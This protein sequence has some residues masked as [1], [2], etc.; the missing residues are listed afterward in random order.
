MFL[1]DARMHWLAIGLIT[2]ATLALLVED[3]RPRL[4]IVL[5]AIALVRWIPFHDVTIW[6]ELVV[7]VGVLLV[8]ATTDSR[9][10]LSSTAAIAVAVVTPAYPARGLLFP[11]VIAACNLIPPPFRLGLAV[12]FAGAVPFARYSFAPL[13]IVAAIACAMPLIERIPVIPQ[14]AAV[15]LFALWPWSGVLARS[16]PALL[17]ATHSSAE[18][19]DRTIV[20][21]Q[22]VS[23]PVPRGAKKVT[24]TMAAGRAQHLWPHAVLGHV[25]MNGATTDFAVGDIA[26]FGFMRREHFLT[27]HNAP[28]RVPVDDVHDFGASAWLN[29]AGRV[30]LP[31]PAGVPVLYVTAVR[32]GITLHIE[33]IEFE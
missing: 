23:V 12:V 26:D 13:L 1:P 15:A 17:R 28:A 18:K 22:S 24:I 5:I 3:S 8:F 4:S 2:S 10:R 30:T 9:G 21:P 20:A 19:L 31:V 7:L 32:P 27:A 29:G 25:A 33:S 16:L 6:R 14:T 11:F